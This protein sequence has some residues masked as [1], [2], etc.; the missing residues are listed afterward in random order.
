LHFMSLYNFNGS[1]A[2]HIAYYQACY[3]VV[4]IVGSNS[5]V[6]VEFVSF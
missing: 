3:I 5:N 1:L 6:C 4:R 2:E